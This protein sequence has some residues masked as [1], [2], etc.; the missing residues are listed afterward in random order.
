VRSLLRIRRFTSDLECA[1]SVILSLALTV[2][3]RDRYTEG[4]C[5]R[6]ATYATALGEELHLPDRDLSALY[7]GAYLH[8][9]GKIGIPDAVLQKPA[10]LSAAELGMMREHPVIGERLCGDLRS[11][12]P[13]RSIVRHHHERLDGRGY[14]DALAGDAVPLLAQIVSIADAYDAITTTRPYRAARTAEHAYAELKGD[15]DKGARDGDLVD[16]F[17]ALGRSGRLTS[18]GA[19]PDAIRR[20]GFE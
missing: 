4:H 1:E 20:G 2:E 7:R 16:A 13:V 5:Q 15:A 9:V 14:P 6:L 8:D 18:S 11:L 10:K 19:T 12:A 3:A 17:I